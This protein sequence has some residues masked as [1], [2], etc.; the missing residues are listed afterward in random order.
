[1]PETYVD[2]RWPDGEG[3]SCYSPSSVVCEFFE[4]GRGYRLAEFMELSKTALHRASDRVLAKYGI[5]CSSAMD[6]LRRLEE[7]AA[8]FDPEATVQILG[9][10]VS[11]RTE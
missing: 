11:R 7:R 2:I 6:Q 3:E 4:P 5:A 9:V 10:R 1:M 8:N